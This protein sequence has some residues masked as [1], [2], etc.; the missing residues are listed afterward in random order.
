MLL[1]SEADQGLTLL[2]A[3][4]EASVDPDRCFASCGDTEKLASYL[5]NDASMSVSIH[6][7][8]H[9]DWAVLHQQTD[10][11]MSQNMFIIS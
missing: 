5:Q 2:E 10:A 8:H 11:A 7:V 1:N 4:S 3:L 9:T 6:K